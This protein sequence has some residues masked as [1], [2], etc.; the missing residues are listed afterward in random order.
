MPPAGRCERSSG[1]MLSRPRKPPSNRSLP[2]GSSRLT[3]QVKLTSS[4]S[5]T[6]LRNSMSRPPSMANTSSA[7]QAWTGGLT[8]EKSHSYAGSAPSGC[9]N[10]SRHS[11]I[12]W[13]LAN[14]GSTWASATQWKA[15]SQAA[16]QGYSQL[17]GMDMMSNAS[18]LRQ[19][20]LR[21]VSPLRRRDRLARVAV[22]PA[23]HVVVEQLL[24][25]HQPGE[26]P[27]G[28]GELVPGGALG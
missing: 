23:G 16:N 8:S 1:P 2:W 6:R 7:A 14:A 4:L 9:W 21:P 18:K 19:R 3:H 28:Q 20:E 17:S 10:H 13:Y 22:Q 15:R 25:P 24:A 12:S 26:G 5:K 11:R 27:A